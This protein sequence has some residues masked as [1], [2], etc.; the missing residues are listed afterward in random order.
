MEQASTHKEVNAESEAR[1]LQADSDLIAR[2]DKDIRKQAV[3]GNDFLTV[4]P[5]GLEDCNSRCQPVNSE[6]ET[7]PA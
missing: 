7:H 2:K 3:C 4:S 1:R 5:Q 6:S